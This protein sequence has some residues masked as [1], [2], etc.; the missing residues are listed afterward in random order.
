MFG[1]TFPGDEPYAEKFF[2]G[3]EYHCCIPHEKEIVSGKKKNEVP[4]VLCER[5]SMMVPITRCALCG[6]PR[7]KHGHG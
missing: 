5:D 2:D 1:H 6:Q 4:R 7:C 3:I